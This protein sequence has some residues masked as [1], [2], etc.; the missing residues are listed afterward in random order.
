MSKKSI[1]SYM[2]HRCNDDDSSLNKT[3]IFWSKTLPCFELDTHLDSFKNIYR[4][5]NVPKLCNFQYCL[6]HNK[7]FCNN[8]LFHW[9]IKDTQQCDYCQFRKQNIPHLMFECPIAQSM[10]AEVAKIFNQNKIEV[11]ISLENV[12]YN[13]VHTIKAHIANL[14]TLLIK[15]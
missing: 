15:L 2:Y 10:W 3:T 4:M 1:S 11:E 8:V 5:T 14:I 13:R 6:L 7:I 9:K 12:I